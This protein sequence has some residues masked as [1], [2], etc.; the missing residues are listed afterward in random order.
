MLSSTSRSPVLLYTFCL[1]SSLSLPVT[2]QPLHTLKLTPISLS[3]PKPPS[4]LPS[5]T[6]SIT[7]TR[8]PLPPLHFLQLAKR[9]CSRFDDQL[10]SKERR[11][12]TEHHTT[13]WHY[14]LYPS[15][16]GQ[17]SH[18]LLG[19]YFMLSPL[20]DFY[21]V[22][23]DPLP[24]WYFGNWNP[25]LISVAIFSIGWFSSPCTN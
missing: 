24:T 17:T 18:W 25:F 6:S 11:G 4:S 14:P 2:L 20:I 23:H 1:F 15:T 16:R 19:V 5:T 21:V 10:F 3:N 9:M 12:F 8:Y 13:R 22:F 7:N